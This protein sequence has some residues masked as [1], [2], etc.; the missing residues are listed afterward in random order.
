MLQTIQQWNIE[1]GPFNEDTRLVTI[2][3][4][5]LYTN[6][7]HE[8]IYT[9]IRK[10]LD[11]DPMNDAPPTETVVDITRHVLR[12]NFFSFEGKFYH[13]IFGTAMGT[14]LAPSAANLFKG[15]LEQRMLAESPIPITTE[16][17]RRFID[18][19]FLL[20]RGTDAELD[21]FINFINSFHPTIRFTVSSSDHQ[22]PFLDIMISLSN[23]YLHTDLYSKPTDSHAY[24]YSTSCHPRHVINNLPYCLF[25]R[26][27]RLC[28]N[29]ETFRSRCD[30]LR[31]QLLRRGH[32]RAIREKARIKASCGTRAQAL[33]YRP[34]CNTDR[35]PMVVTHHPKNPPLRQWLRELHGEL[36]GRSPNMLHAM[37]Q[38]PILGERNNRSV[39]SILM[40]TVIPPASG[41]ED[42]VFHCSSNG[43][44]TFCSQHVIQSG[45]FTSHTTGESFHIRHH[46]T[47]MSKNIIY[48]LFC[49]KCNHTQYVGQTQQ[50]LKLRFNQHFS[51]IRKNTGTLVTH[52]FNK[53]HH[54]LFVQPQMHAYR[55]STH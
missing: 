30:D 46:M 45:T 43:T 6:S 28:S 27:R 47:C 15:W 16:F 1:H 41:G 12:N 9:S 2:D 26:L 35:T 14:P 39:R 29:T 55:A 33:Q 53:Q 20:W 5:G 40:P 3:V 34:Q 17:W 38:P 18:D 48:I 31:D 32:K 19:I 11:E 54:S 42:G 8:D 22:I 24:L 51:N 7:P 10:Y 4:V 13:Q 21:T 52:H 25:L 37:P 50:T 36:V 23:G 49:D 44:C